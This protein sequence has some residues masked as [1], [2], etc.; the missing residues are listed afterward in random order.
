MS[1][2]ILNRSLGDMAADGSGERDCGGSPDR[3][4]TLSY[5]TH[6]LIPQEAVNVVVLM[7]ATGA[8]GRP[9][10]LADE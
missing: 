9:H 6:V 1:A 8:T 7:K 2:Q 5:G 4:G 3:G 10:A